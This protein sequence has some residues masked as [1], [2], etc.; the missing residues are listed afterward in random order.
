MQND[1]ITLY[2]S[3]LADPPHPACGAM[4][5]SSRQ[6]LQAYLLY[7]SLLIYIICIQYQYGISKTLHFDPFIVA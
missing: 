7:L 2:L 5:R 6:D 3:S 1:A 4:D